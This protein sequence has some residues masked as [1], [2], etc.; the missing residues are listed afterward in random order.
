MNTLVFR[1]GRQAMNAM[2]D[3]Q[4]YSCGTSAWCCGHCLQFSDFPLSCGHRSCPQ[5]QH[6]TTCD[7]LARQ[8]AKLLPADYYLVTFT[9]PCEL[10]AVAPNEEQSSALPGLFNLSIF[11][12]CF[13]IFRR[14]FLNNLFYSLKLTFFKF[15]KNLIISVIFQPRWNH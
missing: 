6:H 14:V 7:W 2:L 5:C 8:Q 12:R 11:A 9:L 1:W 15:V 4:T 10:R 3:C 13:H